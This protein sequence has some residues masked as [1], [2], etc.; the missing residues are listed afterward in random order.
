MEIDLAGAAYAGAVLFAAY[1]VRGIAGFGSGLIAV[2]LLALQ[3]P[4]KAV[5]PI[6]VLLDYLGS[7]SQGMRN[8]RIV[9]WREQWPLIPFTLLGV[10]AGLTLLHEMT[11]AALATALGAFIIAYAVYQVLPLPDLYGPRVLAVP[12][13]LLGGLVGTLFGT[14]GP[15]YIIYFGLRR[16][17]KSV[18]RATFAM[19]FLI[20]GGI[21]LIAY[22]TFGFFNPEVLTAALAALP[23]AAVALWV[24]GRIHVSIARETY[25]RVISALLLVSGIGLLM[26]G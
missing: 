1:M 11:S 6:V 10:G 8:R 12:S 2:P 15:F 4:I 18:Q 17:E 3:F 5:V 26:K 14:G 9:A 20:D 16:L 22:A 19:N 21:R 7:A 13:G 25:V 24:G 23:V